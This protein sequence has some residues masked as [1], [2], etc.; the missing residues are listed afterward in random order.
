MQQNLRIPKLTG[1]PEQQ[2]Q[3]LQPTPNL[4]RTEPPD[5][6]ISSPFITTHSLIV[7]YPTILSLSL[8]KTGQITYI[9]LNYTLET[10]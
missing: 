6:E 7:L 8:K 5:E 10:L 1:K 3:N 9:D 2:N 4:Q